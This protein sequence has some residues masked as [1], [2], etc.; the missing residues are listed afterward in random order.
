MAKLFEES[1]SVE[2]KNGC[3]AKRKKLVKINVKNT[4]LGNFTLFWKSLSPILLPIAVATIP[5]ITTIK[6]V[7][8]KL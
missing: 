3:T 5:A 7:V 4:L 6:D 8:K 1:L 2:D